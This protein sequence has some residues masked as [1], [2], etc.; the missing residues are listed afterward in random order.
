MK[1][2]RIYAS[3]SGWMYEVWLAERLL[4]VGWSRTRAAAEH[5]ASLA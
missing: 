3:A 2:V 5:E 1:S 4:V